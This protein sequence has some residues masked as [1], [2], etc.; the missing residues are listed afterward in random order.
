MGYWSPATRCPSSKRI[1]WRSTICFKGGWFRIKAHPSS[2]DFGGIYFG[3]NTRLLDVTC[4]LN[5]IEVWPWPIPKWT[6][7]TEIIFFLL[8]YFFLAAFLVILV[9]LFLTIS[10]WDDY[11]GNACFG[12]VSFEAVL[13]ILPHTFTS[14]NIKS[15]VNAQHTAWLSH[16]R[17][18]L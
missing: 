10:C 3:V 8:T 6:N 7:W 11:L 9:V 1:S 16:V 4:V 2:I 12:K 18:H 13:D 15:M 14:P 5:H 17:I